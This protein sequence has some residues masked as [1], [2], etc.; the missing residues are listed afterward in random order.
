MF[1]FFKKKPVQPETPTAL[2]P[3][4][5]PAPAAH[6]DVTPATASAPPAPVMSPGAEQDKP[7]WMARLKAGLSKTSANLSVLFVGAKIDDDLYDE[8]EAALLMADAGVR[9]RVNYRALLDEQRRPLKEAL[10]EMVTIANPLDYHTFVW[11]NLERQTAAF[12][13]M[14]QG[15]YALNLVVLDFPRADRCDPADWVT[16]VDAVI[17]AAQATG[18]NAGV[19]ASMAENMP[20]AIAE[21]LVAAGVTPFSGIDEALAAAEIAQ[22]GMVID[23]TTK[24]RA[25][26]EINKGTNKNSA[27][28]VN[29][30]MAEEDRRIPF[31]NMIYI[32]DGPSDVPS[33]SVV[34]G[35]GGKSDG[36]YNPAKPEE[37]APNI[38]LRQVGCIDHYGPA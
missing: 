25:I 21:R 26:F 9:Y 31:Q 28:D 4:A 14:M 3:A 13:T 19:V 10:G 29:S 16:T 6:A 33:F 5:A 34:K 17:A 11:G 15:D 20:E 35:N 22:I 37:F 32:A 24:T 2:P 23:N 12:T 8:L 7:N 18:A 27:I 38:L 1:S 36:V 30:K